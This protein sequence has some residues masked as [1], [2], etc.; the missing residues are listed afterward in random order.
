MARL[1]IEVA[2]LSSEVTAGD[3]NAIRVL[4]GFLQHHGHDLEALTNQEQLDT[5]VSE[6]VGLLV[7]QAAAYEQRT[8]IVQAREAAAA[9]R[10]RFRPEPPD[11]PGP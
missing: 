10:P 11:P 5:A 1:L 8:T 9:D 3:N 6:I 7:E 2:T 4:Q